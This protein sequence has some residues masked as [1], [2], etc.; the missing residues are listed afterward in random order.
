MNDWSLNKITALT[1]Q[2]SQHILALTERVLHMADALEARKQSNAALVRELRRG[3]LE[4]QR[5]K[6][7]MAEAVE[8]PEDSNY[9]QPAEAAGD[10]GTDDQVEVLR[11]SQ[12]DPCC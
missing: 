6:D 1:M 5:L 4:N 7:A 12:V 8:A 2:T 9:S 10:N 3:R 11:Q